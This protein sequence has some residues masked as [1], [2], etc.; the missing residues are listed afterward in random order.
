M[1]MRFGMIRAFARGAGLTALSLLCAPSFAAEGLLDIYR[2]AQLNDAVIAAARAELE[3]GQEAAVQGR[4]LLMPTVGISGSSSRNDMVAPAISRNGFNYNSDSYTLTVNQPIYR[5][6]NYA[7][8]VQ[9]GFRV[10]ASEALYA[11]AEQDLILRVSTAYFDLLRAQDDVL[12]LESQKAA[13]V[14]Q[15]NQ[16]KHLFEARVGTLTDLHEAQAQYDMVL[17]KEIEARNARELRLRALQRI[18]GRRTQSIRSLDE[19]PLLMP[20]PNDVDKWIEV[21]ERQNPQVELQRFTLEYVN[22]EIEK[23]RAGHYPTLDLVLSATHAHNPSYFLSG[24]QDT[25]LYA[26]QF[27]MPLFQGGYVNSKVKEV[28]ASKEKAAKDL[29]DTLRA[30]ALQTSESFFLVTSGIAKV[31]ALEQAV[32]SNESAL[33]S[34]IKGREVGLRTSVDV[35]NSQQQLFASKRDLL[36]ARYD[37]IVNRLKLRASV[38][39]LGEE[40]VASVDQWLKK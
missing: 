29:E 39:G 13:I 12:L 2:E 28:T 37:Y 1:K 21:S 17:A 23:S 5:K 38:G 35:L 34:T 3:A 6:Y 31:R 33:H 16:A 40:D 30:S 24:K 9:S 11:S 8:W 27:N 19:L 26:L 15:L 7:S 25:Q 18:I 32:K 36:Q 4:S 14:E 20:V 22:Q 10:K